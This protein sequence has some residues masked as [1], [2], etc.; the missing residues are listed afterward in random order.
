MKIAP[1][2]NRKVIE[3]LYTATASNRVEFYFNNSRMRCMLHD[4]KQDLK[5]CGTTSNEALHAEATAASHAQ[6]KVHTWMTQ[7]HGG[8]IKHMPQT[9]LAYVFLTEVTYTL[10]STTMWNHDCLWYIISHRSI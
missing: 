9:C 6:T 1:G 5:P 2:P 8:S 10:L 3:I 4:S 7:S